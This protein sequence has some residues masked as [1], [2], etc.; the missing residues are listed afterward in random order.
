MKV[1][2]T[3]EHGNSSYLGFETVRLGCSNPLKIGE[4][5]LFLDFYRTQKDVSDAELV[6]DL[7]DQSAPIEK[8]QKELGQ[9]IAVNYYTCTLCEQYIDPVNDTPCQY[10]TIEGEL[11]EQSS[12]QLAV[13][14]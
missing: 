14:E 7:A 9:A 5:F 8:I 3:R 6:Q 2:S 10:W 13:V 1:F 12:E 11:I 4:I